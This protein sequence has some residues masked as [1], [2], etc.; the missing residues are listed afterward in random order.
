MKIQYKAS[1]LIFTV[2][3]VT[4][5]LLLIVL[6]VFGKALMKKEEI[7]NLESLSRDT[8]DHI[9][10]FLEEK[11]SAVITLSSAPIIEASLLD[12]NKKFAALPPEDRQKQ[13]ASL[14]GKWMS[15]EHAE[16]PFIGNCL[17]NPAAEYFRRQQTLLPNMYAEIFLTNRF[18]GTVACTGKLTTFAHAHKYWW[19][20]SYNGGRGKIFYDDRG[21]DTSANQYVLGITVPVKKNNEVIGILKCNINVIGTLSRIVES[22]KQKSGRILKIVR[23]GGLIVLEPAK[24]P[25]SA[26]ISDQLLGCLQKKEVVSSIL[27]Q[28]GETWLVAI[29]P[30]GITAGSER[31]GFGGNPNSADHIKG[32]AGEFWVTAIFLSQEELNAAIARLKKNLLGTGTVFILVIS[33]FALWLGRKITK[34]VI[35]LLQAIE[36]IGKG[37]FE[38]RIA[39]SAEDEFAELAASVNRMTENLQKETDERRAAEKKLLQSRDMLEHRVNARTR[40][41]QEMNID[42]KNEIEERKQAVQSLNESA[43]W[44]KRVFHSLDESVLIVSPDRTIVDANAATEHIFGYTKEELADLS[45]EVL[46]ADREHYLE[47]GRRIREAFDRDRMAVFEFEA[48]RKNGEV[49]PSEHTVSFLKTDDGTPLGIV[50]VVRDIS[51]QKEAEK[52]LQMHQEELEELVKERT[53]SLEQE[54]EE[55]E[56]IAEYSKKLSQAVEASP[57]SVVITDKDGN[58]EYVNR[59]FCELTQYDI[60]EVI[61]QNPRV[62]KS[63]KHED[64]FYEELWQTIKSGKEWHGEFCNKKKDGSLFWERASI[65]PIKN[66]QGE[67]THF[68]GV[69]EDITAV[70][71]M[72]RNLEEARKEAD[73]ANEAKTVFLS[74]MSHELRTPLNSVLGFA[75]LLMEDDGNLTFEERKSYTDK[76]FRSSRHLLRLISDILDLA[77]IE[78]GRIDLS[79]EIIEPF[80]I[81]E[82]VLELMQPMADRYNVAIGASGPDIP[83]YIETDSTRYQ[84][85]MLNL[86]SNAIKYN[87]PEGAVSI[88]VTLEGDSVHLSIADTGPGIPDDQLVNLFEPF[89]RLGAETSSIDGTGIGLTIT[90]L[91]T[92]QMNG[93]M[94]FST[95]VGKGTVFTVTF[96]RIQPPE[97]AEMSHGVQA[98]HTQNSTPKGNYRLLYIEDNEFN[99]HLFEAIVSPHAHLSLHMAADAGQGIA[100]ARSLKPDLIFMDIGLPDMDGYE[101]FKHLNSDPETRDIPIVALSANAMPLDIK[102]AKAAG[103]KEYL[104]KPF[105]IGE[106]FRAISNILEK[107]D[108]SR[109]DT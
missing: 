35:T 65:G 27:K 41:L 3:T 98:Q 9:Q 80:S 102:K 26:R 109:N 33:V 34:P 42:L 40:E 45:T 12:S 78:S 1:V 95:E 76:I 18:G 107:G 7:K 85:I 38:T 13:I 66:A 79:L 92:E 22:V 68:V 31:Y 62:L 16:A 59:K 46:H 72:I 104:T 58:I 90:R 73:R 83:V 8:A 5:L 57:V 96:P 23:S 11:T 87:V 61:S 99:R 91:L 32:N 25:L 82:N 39:F 36:N 101:A 19:T 86:V 6:S 69:K 48:R 94:T 51:R 49:F 93:Q 29:A 81:A 30:V 77:R 75:Q 20:A 84:Q 21:F 2:G 17:K 103:F 24:E 100:A 15:A 89:N 43:M 54:I 14:N 50:S 106:L 47:F 67:I 44:M 70:K 74:S 28:N 88:S 60:S 56:K 4:L 10:A 97:D 55:R 108:E 37:H 63:G 71:T 64:R 105:N 53:L 52:K